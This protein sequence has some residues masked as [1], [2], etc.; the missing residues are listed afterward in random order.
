M[1]CFS[2]L[3]TYISIC[4]ILH[5]YSTCTIINHDRSGEIIVLYNFLCLPATIFT[6]YIGYWH[7]LDVFKK[8]VCMYT[9][10]GKKSQVI[11]AGQMLVYC[12]EW[13][14]KR[15]CH[16]HIASSWCE[17]EYEKYTCVGILRT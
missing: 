14:S 10:I 9:C 11:L 16:F 12:C 2:H 8:C 3:S 13:S 5:Y 1:K 6:V 15:A 4:K 7:D 17:C